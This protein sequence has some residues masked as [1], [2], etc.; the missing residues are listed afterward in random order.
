MIAEGGTDIGH[1]VS[2]ARSDSPWGPFEPCPHNPIL[3]N[4]PIHT[5]LDAVGHGDLIQDL[6][7]KWWMVFLGFRYANPYF[8][9][10]GRETLI[11]PVEWNDDGWPVVNKTGTIDYE[12]VL[13]R[14]VNLHKWQA[15]PV[16]DTFEKRALNWVHLRNPQADKYLF[17]DG[18]TLIGS[19]LPLSSA[20]GSPTMLLSR[21]QHFDMRISAKFNADLPNA[22]DEVGLTVYYDFCHHYDF[23][24]TRKDDGVYLVVGKTIGDLSAQVYCNMYDGNETELT[25]RANKDSYYF[26]HNGI[27]CATG[28]TQYVST[29]A[30]TIS[31]TGVMV[32]MFAV[33]KT[34]KGHFEWFE[35]EEAYD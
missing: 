24:L 15:K 31:F 23:Y 3:S 18:L 14:E 17:G 20:T 12:T 9:H 22:G 13:D 26:E 6:Q 4:Q 8:H 11:A 25:I 33:G 32:G 28:L 10:L 34:A 19:D 27:K 29:E 2:I 30:T 5:T 35:E 16:R 21:Q 7:G 1:R